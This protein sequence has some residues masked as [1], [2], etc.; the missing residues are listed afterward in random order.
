MGAEVI[1]RYRAWVESL[2]V[3]ERD[4][5]YLKFQDRFWTPNEVL[6]EME[7]GTP[8]GKLLQEAEEKLMRRE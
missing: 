4:E 3:F 7:A 6:S 5:R 8:T 2:P 1:L